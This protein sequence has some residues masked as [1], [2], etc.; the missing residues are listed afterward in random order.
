VARRISPTTNA[1][2]SGVLTAQRIRVDW[3]EADC[4]VIGLGTNDYYVGGSRTVAVAAGLIE[5]Q[6]GAITPGARVWWVNVYDSS[7]PGA[8]VGSRTFNRALDERAAIDN[9]FEVVDWYTLL[10]ANPTWSTDGVHVGTTG[11]I[12]RA[13][14]VA[15]ALAE[16]P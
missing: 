4:W 7:T 16:T 15:Q 14:L 1:D 6:L 2:L 9:R 11:S 10:L 3:G 8:L 5:Q 13:D 12:R